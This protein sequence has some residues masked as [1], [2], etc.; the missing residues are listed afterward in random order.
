MHAKSISPAI[1]MYSHRTSISDQRPQQSR[2]IDLG[3]HAPI[4]AIKRRRLARGHLSHH[5]RNRIHLIAAVAFLV[6]Q[7]TREMKDVAAS[8]TDEKLRVC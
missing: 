5:I 3:T 1:L 8:E 4:E 2:P 7:K 6:F